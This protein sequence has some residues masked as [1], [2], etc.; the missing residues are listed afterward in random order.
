MDE[1]TTRTVIAARIVIDRRFPEAQSTDARK[2]ELE[3]APP[4]QREAA[5]RAY[6]LA[7]ERERDAAAASNIKLFSEW[8]V[9]RSVIRSKLS[10]YYP[11]SD[12]ATEWEEYA[13]HVTLYV[14][15]ASGAS[16]RDLKREYVKELARF[17]RESP[18]GWLVLVNDPRDLSSDEYA[19]YILADGRLSDSVLR[20][21]NDLVRRVLDSHIAGFS[22]DL[23][24]LLEDLMPF[25]D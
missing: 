6:R 13:N 17:L 7:L 10:A 5:T 25:Y 15:L 24:D 3:T 23:G 1:L 12:L 14:R 9:T 11:A 22:T 21:K 18:I 16:T 8:L 20:A 2:G 4:V 19:A